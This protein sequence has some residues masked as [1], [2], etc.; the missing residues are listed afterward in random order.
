[1]KPSRELIRP[2]AALSLLLCS[3]FLLAPQARAE[4]PRIYA[5]TGVVVVPAPGKRIEDATVVLR[6]GLVE[7]VGK[8][9]PVPADA[10]VIAAEDDWTVYPAFIDAA[11]S[12]GLD[13]EASAAASGGPPR[14]D[15]ESRPG[16]PH[17]LSSVHP[18][19]SVVDRLDVGHASFERHRELGFAVAQVL[20]QSGLFRGQSAVVLLRDGPAA[21]LILDDRL[22]QVIAFEKSSFMARQYP[23]S[24]IGAIAA[25]RQ[26]LLDAERQK[27]WNERYAK[28]PRGMPHPEFHSSDAALLKLLGG[29]EP[30]VFVSLAALDPLRFR[31]IA[32]HFRLQAMTVAQGLGDRPEYLVDAGM[33]VLLPLEM[34]E[35]PDLDDPEAVLD[36]SLDEMQALVR[37]P[38]LPAE[39]NEAGVE[40]AFVTAGMKSPRSFSEN[41]V[42]V[43]E[44]GLSPDKALAALTTVPAKLLGMDRTLGRIEPG[45][46]ANLIVV[47]GE[48]FTDKPVFRHVFIDGY[49]EEIEPQET[50]GDPN[51]VV[52]PRG[53][54]E[55]VTEVMGRRGESSWTISGRK[56]AYT[57][58]SESERTGKRPFSRVDLKGNALTVVSNTP[59]GEM[60]IT[61][62]ID[63]DELSGDT[64][65]ESPRG[66]IKMTVEGHRVSG[67]EGE[68]Q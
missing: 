38:Q 29:D 42:K 11:S 26:T 22:A 12:V 66:S 14:G 39:L 36:V 30:A 65:M 32:N 34:P 33:P 50:I 27:V 20:P 10:E 68:Q 45:M 24:T 7:A 13:A 5:I 52:D 63:E 60:E 62:V 28:D 1:M 2:C 40:F 47:Q 23:S 25:V 16:S 61:V 41:L 17:E 59:R 37:A 31:K 6:D 19:Q 46:Q 55:I 35:K 3:L 15:E 56:D 48:L 57:G 9:I 43:V 18:E 54:W 44:A 58:F 21:E 8:D 53:R 64:Q 4:R 67:P 49:H 51:A